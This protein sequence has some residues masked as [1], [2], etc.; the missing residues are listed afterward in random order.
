MSSVL[1]PLE[2]TMLRGWAGAQPKHSNEFLRQG[3]RVQFRCLKP[4]TP[5]FE[6]VALVLGI[7]NMKVQRILT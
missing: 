4:G 1:A 2:K 5:F 3:H 7:E 6:I